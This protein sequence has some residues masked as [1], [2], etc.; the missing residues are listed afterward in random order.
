MSMLSRRAMMTH[1]SGGGL[2]AGYTE[3]AYI[4]STGEQWIDTGEYIRTDDSF[5]IQYKD[6]YMSARNGTL[7]VF[8]SSYYDYRRIDGITGY[9]DKSY[10]GVAYAIV[11]FAPYQG[12]AQ[13]ITLAESASTSA[14]QTITDFIDIAYADRTVNISVN[15]VP[16]EPTE[17]T[18]T[19]GSFTSAPNALFAVNSRQDGVTRKSSVK[20]YGYSH[21]R[22]GQYLR[23]FVP[24]IRSDNKPGFYDLAGSICP[25]TGTP[26][27]I[28]AGTGA[29]L[30]A[31]P[32][33]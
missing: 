31:G 28:N 12:E 5:S 2:P 1:K 17:I 10:Y 18:V 16:K 29:D 15:G 22:N 23:N 14:E 30:I 25:L 26:F 32:P 21:G 7:G 33:V 6:I 9:M 8:G 19:W 3:V 13:E 20:I 24:C 27:Y 4:Q 11:R